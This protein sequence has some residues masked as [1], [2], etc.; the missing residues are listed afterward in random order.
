[1]D[2]TGTNVQKVKSVRER[3]VVSSSTL[4]ELRAVDDRAKVVQR[5]SCVMNILLS[6]MC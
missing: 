1:M 5:K 2:K 3:V 4:D 6:I